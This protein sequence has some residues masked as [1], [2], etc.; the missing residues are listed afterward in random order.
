VKA[1]DKELV[2]K[3]KMEDE[4]LQQR[5]AA[6]GAR[7][8]RYNEAAKRREEGALFAANQKNFYRQLEKG[9][10][11]ES[12]RQDPPSA[13]SMTTFWSGNWSA[14][15]QHSED[16]YCIADEVESCVVLPDMP[17]AFWYYSG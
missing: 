12:I 13:S 4:R 14:S 1:N 11:N 3:L 9:G 6:L 5:V 2:K 16:A 15:K 17:P 7:I 8:R 10:T